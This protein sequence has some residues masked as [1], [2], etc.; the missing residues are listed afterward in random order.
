MSTAGV[1]DAP[2]SKPDWDGPD[3]LAAFDADRLGFLAEL[4]AQHGD[5]VPFRLGQ[6]RAV[7]V[8]DP[9]LVSEMLVGPAA[10]H[11]SKDY[12]SDLVPW[13]IR[14]WLLLED[15]DSWLTERR[16]A[17][18]AFRHD[19]LVDYAVVIREESERLAREWPEGDRV[20]VAAACRTLT[21]RVLCRS[22]FGVDIGP[23]LDTAA[24]AIDLVLERIDA[25]VSRQGALASL[26]SLPGDAALLL[27]LARLEWQLDRTIRERRGER[28][29]RPDLLSQ[30]VATVMPDGRAMSTA[31]IRYVVVPL[32][33][34]GHETTANALA[35]TLDLLARHPAVLG[36][37]RE[38]LAGHLGDRP[39]TDQDLRHLEYLGAV[40]SESL[41]LYPPIWGFGRL[42]T[43]ETTIGPHTIPAGTVVWMSQ[44][45]IHR[46]A[47]W[48]DRPGEFRPERWL[49]EPSHAVPK[50][51]YF[52]FGA[53]SRRC[54]G[55]TFATWEGRLALATLLRQVDLRPVSAAAPSPQPSFTLRPRPGIPMLVSHIA[56]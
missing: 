8:S 51:A 43:E 15:P 45:V 39:V 54:L 52:P 3:R 21:L 31:R 20:D 48:F 13:V 47:R 46:D 5:F 7:L 35:W 30:L 33:F 9:E 42:A 24:R 56:H 34:A 18:P 32:F 29:P 28:G 22:F 36:R 10:R 25:R 27:S 12:L 23:Q 16:L 26:R 49:E 55:S 6:R 2:L 14:R 19:R 17:T 40:F 44:W 1:L 53:G 37:V 4:A 41:R 38:E 11:F 50:L